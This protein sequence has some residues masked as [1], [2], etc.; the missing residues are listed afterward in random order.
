M[1]TYNTYQTTTTNVIS[2][3]KLFQLRK[4]YLLNGLGVDIDEKSFLRKNV[5]LDQLLIRELLDFSTLTCPN[6][7]KTWCRFADW[8]YN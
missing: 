2:L 8:A 7:V 6:L 3:G 5:S 4:Q 1:I